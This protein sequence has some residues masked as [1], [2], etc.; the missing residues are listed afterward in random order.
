MDKNGHR[1]PPG[2]CGELWA[3][4]PQAGGGYLN[5]PEKT[6]EVFIQNPF[7]QEADYS[8][9]YRTGDIVRYRYDGNI[10]FVGRKD[11][12]VKVRGFRIELSEVEAVLREF[13]GGKDAT[14]AAF[15]HPGGGKFLAAYVVGDTELDTQAI[16]DFIGERKPPYMVPE[17]FMQLDKIPLNQNSKVNRRAL[18]VPELTMPE[19]EET[20]NRP[21][22][23]LE[24][25][26]KQMVGGIIGQDNMPLSIPL[27]LAGVTSIGFIRL[28]AMIYRQYGISIPAKKF[29]GI[30]LLGIENEILQAWM[31]PKKSENGVSGFSGRGMDFL[32]LKCG[33]DGRLHGV[34]EESGKHRLQS[35]VYLG[36]FP[37]HR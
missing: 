33:P 11:G 28:S 5:Q 17:A 18:P 13:P 35:S 1:L 16:A 20:A 29:K 31:C 2:A 10:E 26:L 3:A 14:V 19:L 34:H 22:N 37:G 4:G 21:A 25:K 27:E 8:H 6:T 12:Q 9:V 32:S 23:L 7:V 15:D 30:N 36:I 24:E